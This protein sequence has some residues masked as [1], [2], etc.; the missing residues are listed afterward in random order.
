[1]SPTTGYYRPGSTWL[2]RR[3]RSRSSSGSALVL[4]AAFILP[5]IVLVVLAVILVAVAA[6]AGLLRP[7]VRALRIPLVLLTSIVVVNALFF[8]GRH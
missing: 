4:L 7:L 6:S 5:P 8:P 3:T 2:H 1:M